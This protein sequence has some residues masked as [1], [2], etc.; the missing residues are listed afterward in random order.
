MV[1][2]QAAA[3]R[4]SLAADSY[5]LALYIDPKGSIVPTSNP[6]IE[7]VFQTYDPDHLG[8]VDYHSASRAYQRESIGGINLDIR[9]L[10]SQRMQQTLYNAQAKYGN[11]KTEL[12]ATYIRDLVAREAG[13]ST[14]ESDLNTTLKELFQT[15]F[16]EKEYLG[17]RP[18]PDGGLTFPVQVATGQTHDINELSSGEKEVLYGYLR[19]RNATP[20]NSTI[21]LDEP[22]LHLNPALLR[23]FPDFDHRH[24]GRARNQLWLVTHSD[25]L[26]RQAVGNPNY[27]VFHMTIVAGDAMLVNQAL[28][29]VAD[30]D[31]ER[32]TIDLV[33]DL[34]TYRPRNKVVLFEGGGDTEFD[35]LLTQ[36]LFPVF[37]KS[38]NLLSGG[39]KQRVRELYEL[40][41]NAAEQVGM[42]ER[43][44]AITDRDSEAWEAP[45]AG[46][47]QLTW[48]VYHIENYLLVPAYVQ[49][50]TELIL[51]RDP[52]ESDEDV[53]EALR[54]AAAT[55]LPSLTVER[56]RA[57]VNRRVV[58]SIS[59]GVSP[60][61]TNVAA[62]LMPSIVG[63]FDRL[64]A[65]RTE[66]TDAQR[67]SKRRQ[68]NCT[69]TFKASLDDG[70]WITTLPGRAILKGFVAQQLAGAAPYEAFRNV[71]L[72][73]MVD[74]A[75]EPIGMKRVLDL[76]AGVDN[77]SAT[78]A[79]V[80]EASP[81]AF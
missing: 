65:A 69:R 64:D 81:S 4:E 30:D 50:A 48:D 68:T 51:S 58:S 74:D 7:V 67:G 25:T 36:R 5:F 3:L 59:L 14:D 34:A 1:T 12:A 42:A 18:A 49:L 13:V 73:Q 60:S 63:S 9:N 43:F 29:V 78:A 47:H 53:L 15:F 70:T 21:L 24:L 2:E 79:G 80:D 32:A 54:A 52:F 33:G 44:F 75:Y 39:S 66:V 23:G 11:V 61:P 46:A 6:T 77:V 62:A 45:P 22:E 38:V 17:V 20:T 55:L 8:L 37:A 35:V 26:L 10:E 28:P 40:L 27:S 71:V 19:L 72:D 56:L 31:L 16:P 57:E 41:A 76:I